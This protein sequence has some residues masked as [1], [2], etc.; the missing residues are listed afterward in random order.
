MKKFANFVVKGRY[1]FLG[2][3]FVLLV[4]SA[5]LMNFVNVNYDLTSY[6]P[7]NSSTKESIELMQEEFGASGTANIMITHITATDAEVLATSLNNIDGI[8]TAVMSKYDVNSS[9]AL[10][11]IFLENGNYTQEAEDTVDDIEVVLT[12]NLTSEQNFYLTGSAITAEASR[13]AITTEIPIILL[14]AIAIVILILM[15]TTRSW[16][17]PIILLMVIGTAILINM[18]T[19]Y[20]LGQISFI[21]NSIS[22]VLLIALAMDYSIVLVNRFREEREKNPDIYEA[23]K[24]ALAGSITT[25]I[26]S[27]CTVMA[28]LISLVFMNYKIGL[29][30]GLVLTKG[31]F[32]SILAVIF[33]M[34]CLLLLFAKLL[35]K[36]EHKNFLRGLKHIGTFAKY[37]RYV[38]PVLFLVIIAG[39]FTIQTTLLDFYYVPRFSDTTSQEYI[40]ESATEEVFG[41]QNSLVLI[42]DNKLSIAEQEEIFDSVT[43]IAVGDDNELLI[44]SASSFATSSSN[45]M[46]LGQLLNAEALQNTFGLSQLEALSIIS[47]TPTTSSIPNTAYAFEII[48]YLGTD[49]TIQQYMQSSHPELV[50]AVST[51]YSQEQLADNIYNSTNYTRFVFNIN[52]ATDSDLSIEFVNSLHDYLDTQD[53]TYYLVNN[54][55]NVIE[56]QSVFVTDRLLVELI[57]VIAILLIVFLAFRSVSI[58]LILVLII[59]GAIFI[60]L[61]GNALFG[62]SIF[63]ICYLLGTAIQMGATIDYGILLTD[64]YVFARRKLNKF[65]A[66]KTAIDKSF[67][68]II[69]SGSILT[70][71]AFCIGIFS[72]VP[73]ISSIGYVIGFGA[74][75]ASITIL[76]VLPQTLLLLDKVIEKTTLHTTFYNPTKNATTPVVEVETTAQKVN[77]KVKSDDLDNI[78]NE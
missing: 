13:N 73:L 40:S 11:D 8:A 59:Q 60:N 70:L 29:D 45:G 17:E 20:L 38:M 76:F 77:E 2:I 34:P 49:A 36:T 9:S 3:F 53:V 1:W 41:V 65:E 37:T 48:E 33:L 46:S 27:G 23:M 32:I 43:N 26:A 15:I 67:V 75:I 7:D 74:L 57:S 72:S 5:V 16:I 61:A 44:N 69:S 47:N 19:N 4:T 66:I 24:K 51:L 64:R 6:L 63:F 25:I 21:S 35:K 42:L 14:I 10:I 22:S 58:P 78:I 31:V 12:N 30:L 18:G 56:T 52:S 54:T 39:A 50:G 62:N 68:T 55:Q 71:A 28:G